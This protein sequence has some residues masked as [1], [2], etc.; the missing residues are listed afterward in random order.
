MLRQSLISCTLSGKY[1]LL[2]MDLSVDP[3][4]NFY[5]YTC[6]NYLKRKEETLPN[7][8][9]YFVERTEVD[10]RIIITEQKRQTDTNLLKIMKNAY[11]SCK[12]G[13]TCEATYTVTLLWRKNTLNFS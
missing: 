12:N 4:T 10:V 11:E 3:C 7:L 2:G 9:Q 5:E 1:M 6:G 13:G 8:Y